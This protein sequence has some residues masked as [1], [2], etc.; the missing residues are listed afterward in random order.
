[1]MLHPAAYITTVDY[2][3]LV[4][5]FVKAIAF[6]FKNFKFFFLHA[7]ITSLLISSLWPL[8]LR[9]L[10]S[11]GRAENWIL[12][13]SDIVSES[14]VN[15]KKMSLTYLGF[16]SDDCIRLLNC[17]I[18]RYAAE[19]YPMFISAFNMTKFKPDLLHKDEKVLFEALTSSDCL[20]VNYQ[21]ER[22]QNYL[23]IAEKLW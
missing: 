1:M 21:C 3:L 15:M 4:E 9:N 6:G 12:H 10:D 14:I 13:G 8:M 18:G 2:R 11:T 5:T 16:G 17:K 19:N 23:V 22:L 7:L 20:N